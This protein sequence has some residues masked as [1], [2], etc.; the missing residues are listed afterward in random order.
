MRLKSTPCEGALFRNCELPCI[1]CPREVVRA[2]LPGKIF[3]AIGA[4]ITSAVAAR[5][6]NRGIAALGLTEK[7][8]FNNVASSGAASLRADG[9]L[10]LH[11]SWVEVAAATA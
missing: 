2:E 1:S 4:V 9:L 8:A 7:N 3:S 10:F 5:W 6:V 11:A